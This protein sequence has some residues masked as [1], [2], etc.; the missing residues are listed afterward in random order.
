MGWLVV[1]IIAAVVVPMA[2]PMYCAGVISKPPYRGCR[3]VVVGLFGRC[4]YHRF[5]P[6][7]RF[8][9]L[10]GGQ[11]LLLRRVCDKCGRP[12]VFGRHQES[13]RPFLG[14]AGYP[15]CTRSIELAR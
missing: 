9:Q 10:L 3:K 6:R 5:Q 12:R 15:A 7:R 1:V 4:Y 14:C 8:I 2:V 13:G 11:K